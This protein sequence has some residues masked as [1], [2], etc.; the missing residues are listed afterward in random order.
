VADLLRE[1]LELQKEL[2][3][4]KDG[5]ETMKKQVKPEPPKEKAAK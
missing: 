4:V 1:L 5:L 2:K 3:T